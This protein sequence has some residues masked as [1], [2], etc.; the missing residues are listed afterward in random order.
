MSILTECICFVNVRKIHN[1]LPAGH[2][3]IVPIV[4]ENTRITRWL[5]G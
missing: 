2:L 3:S 5:P 4:V 1:K